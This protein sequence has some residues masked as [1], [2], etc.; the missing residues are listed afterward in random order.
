M[1]SKRFDRV[2]A[3][4]FVSVLPLAGCNGLSMMPGSVQS[5]A[6]SQR[7][8]S[9]GYRRNAEYRSNSLSSEVL[10]ASKVTLKSWYRQGEAAGVLFKTDGA[11]AG[12]F[13]GTFT[14]S[15]SWGVYGLSVCAFGESFTI[16]SGSSSVSGTISGSWPVGSKQC[17][18]LLGKKFEPVSLDYELKDGKSGRVSIRAI[19]KHDFHEIFFDFDPDI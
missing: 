1:G 19:R 10:T 14:A 7:L 8:G 4:I 3:A 12:P 11:A 13:P 16:K 15:G 17:S 2:P 6:L 18:A 5:V 9:D